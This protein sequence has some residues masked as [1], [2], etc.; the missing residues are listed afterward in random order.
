MSRFGVR[1]APDRHEDLY[2]YFMRLCE[3]NGVELP[4]EMLS[5]CP[6]SR[7]LGKTYGNWYRVQYLSSRSLLCQLSGLSAEKVDELFERSHPTWSCNT[8]TVIQ[9]LR[10]SRPR[11]CVG[12]V[13][14]GGSQHRLSAFL[15][16]TCCPV[17]K[18]TLIEQ[19][20]Q[21]GSL[22]RWHSKIL[23]EC[24]SCLTPWQSFERIDG[25]SGETPAEQDLKRSAT[26]QDINL[27]LL[28]DFS[29][30][31]ALAARPLDLER[32]K[33]L[34][35]PDSFVA[36][37][38]ASVAYSLMSSHTARERHRRL[39][40]ETYATHKINAESLYK[41]VHADLHPSGIEPAPS[42]FEALD[43]TN[44]LC[45]GRIR[46]LAST[47]GIP[48]H[49]LVYRTRFAQLLGVNS[50][51]VDELINQGV[52]SS[53]NQH[54]V[55]REQIFDAREA[56]KLCDH[57]V[58]DIPESD[59][60][61]Q[62][63]SKTASLFDGYLTSFGRLVAA[64][65]RDEIKAYRHGTLDNFNS[66]VIKSGELESW[67][68]QEFERACSDA[69]EC[70]R[71]IPVLKR[72]QVVES[73]DTL[74]RQGRLKIAPWKHYGVSVDGTSLLKLVTLTH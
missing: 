25:F 12:C 63:V 8:N 68:M 4:H 59:A 71:V 64:I 2:G 27:S 41:P 29:E 19:C 72:S 55:L 23:S 14:E 10:A 9:S 47:S 49:F 40:S 15:F 17:H 67:L 30:C 26:H 7:A 21:C 73:I 62:L 24:P 65:I 54:P 37:P 13:K 61:F 50:I 52:L 51:D 38:V 66:V 44:L 6:N 20:P 31:F 57:L 60:C 1:P 58:S 43:T 34:T 35:V 46:K 45:S 56:G 69:I 48:S 70:S 42:T 53:A 74:F 16:T 22:T 3:R 33:N 28:G 36:I 18:S 11:I 32:P 5:D 39:F